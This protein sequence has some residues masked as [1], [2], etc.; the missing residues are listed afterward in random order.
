MNTPSLRRLAP[1]ALAAAF[2]V[3]FAPVARA[4]SKLPGE[5]SELTPEVRTAAQ[6]LVDVIVKG[7]GDVA[8]AR[9][10]LLVMGPAIWPVVDNALRLAPPDAA[11]PHLNYLKALLVKKVEPEFEFLRER[12]RRTSLV[13]APP[14]LLKELND[15]RIGRPVPAKPGKRLPPC[16]TP[17]SD[18]TKTVY[19]SGDG[20]IVLAFGADAT[21]QSPDAVDVG[22]SEAA[23]GFVMAVGGKPVPFARRSG[24]GANVTVSAPMG[25]ARVGHRQ[26]GG[27]S[28]R[29]ARAAR[30]Q[31]RAHRGRGQHARSG[32]GGWAPG[33]AVGRRRWGIGMPRPSLL[34]PVPAPTLFRGPEGPDPRKFARTALRSGRTLC[35]S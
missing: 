30:Q 34:H 33:G 5:A 21:E 29:A 32:A 2:A 19:R 6:K 35:R 12:L 24:K 22:V 4:D 17:S 10:G 16:V 3:S 15:F 25:Y 28:R 27:S 23:A 18:G 11:R 13:G 1:L 9:R 14:A 8:K 7:E 31:R 26:R 20:T